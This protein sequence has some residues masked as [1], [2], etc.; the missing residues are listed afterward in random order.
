MKSYFT[1]KNGVTIP[2]IG[3]GTWQTPDGQT[4]I[5]SICEAVKCGYRHIDTAAAYNNETSVGEGIRRCGV[6]RSE[7]FITSKVWNT[8]RGYDDAMAGFE[9]TMSDLGLEYLD[10][11][12]IHWPAS[13][14]QFANWKE[15]NAGTWK[16]MEEQYKAGR[17]RA[18]GLSNFFVDHMQALFETAEIM[19][20]VN[21]IEF[22]PGLMR[23]E[24][25]DFC[26]KNGI[27]VQA[28]SPLGTGRMLGNEQ[29][30]AIAAKYGVS[31]AQ[32]CIRWVLQND[33]LPLAKS[34][35]PARIKQ[36]LDVFGFE[37]SKEDMN[38]INAMPYFGGSALHPDEIDF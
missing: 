21:Q 27:L 31:T 25:V 4:A 36:N 29:L 11:Y 12:L 34:V 7:L 5:D 8:N 10:L 18:I 3:F 2:S 22:H 32:L 37:I 38:I 13:K 35:T 1:M 24:V 14:S 26:R 20:M 19:P 33:V 28:W 9:K 15:L 16:A 30:G 6:D 23:P 17:I